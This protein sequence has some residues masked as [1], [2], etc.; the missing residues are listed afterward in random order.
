MGTTQRLHRD[1]AAPEAPEN[2]QYGE[3][4]AKLFAVGVE[5]VAEVQ[6]KSIDVA[7]QQTTEMLDVWK[8]AVQ[9]LPGAPALF[10][11]DLAGSGFDR[12]AESQ[13]EIIDLFVEQSHAW[14][15]MLKE[16]TTAAAKVNEGAAAYAKQSVERVVATHKQLLDR[17]A[18][19]A[20]E[21]LET[22][23][24]HFGVEGSP[25]EAATDSIQRGVDAIVDAQK[26]LLDMAIR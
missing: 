15:D 19:H 7:A 3:Q 20:K 4:F 18:A 26:E 9:K 8:K 16:R 11:F 17:S 6:K 13:R 25:V 1:P 14:A 21:V 2:S 12:Y 10:L 5:R 23:R 22:S 24:K